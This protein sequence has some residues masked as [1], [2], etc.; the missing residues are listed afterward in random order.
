MQGITKLATLGGGCF[1]CL[2]AMFQRLNGVSSVKSGYSGGQVKNPTYQ[3]VCT[4]ETGHA[5]VIQLSYDPEK[6][7]YN[8]LVQIFLYMHDPTT[9]NR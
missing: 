3:Q 7:T 4:G 2:E 5:E 1:W 8:D 9:L 6:I